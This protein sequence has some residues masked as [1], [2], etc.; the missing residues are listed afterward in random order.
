MSLNDIITML[1]GIKID[2]ETPVPFTYR[3]FP[4]GSAP[5][6]PFIC[7]LLDSIRPEGADNVG[8]PITTLSI[9]LHTDSK[10]FAL[11]SK[12]EA[13]LDSNEMVWTK[14]E[15]WLDDERMQMTTY[16]TEVYINGYTE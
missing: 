12:V 2:E 3:A 6:T 15:A 13:V 9:E 7:Y 10:D 8:I 5:G 16:E 14:E 11:E 1:N 4:V